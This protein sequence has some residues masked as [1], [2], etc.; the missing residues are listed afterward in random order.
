MNLSSTC[1]LVSTAHPP[2]WLLHY[3]LS[4][5]KT[6]VSVHIISTFGVPILC[7]ELQTAL[8]L[9]DFE[10]RLSHFAGFSRS[11]G[12]GEIFPREMRF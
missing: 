10:C 12:P 6:P 7:K 2:E 4:S 5:M 9:S 3:R 1:V 8:G 11:A